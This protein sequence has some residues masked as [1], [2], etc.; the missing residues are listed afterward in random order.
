[1]VLSLLQAR[2]GPKTT[3]RLA[4]VILFMSHLQPFD[5]GF[6]RCYIE[7]QMILE[8]LSIFVRVWHRFGISLITYICLC[9][10]T[11]PIKSNFQERLNFKSKVP[12]NYQR[13]E[14][15]QKLE[16]NVV[17]IGQ[18]LNHQVLNQKSDLSILKDLGT[19][20][21][22]MGGTNRL[23]IKLHYPGWM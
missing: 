23:S 22:Y 19:I 21:Y 3:A 1:M 6:R 5:V 17:L 9:R 7:A 11:Q 8:L 13:D 2:L 4:A 20:L 15:N 18:L 16:N 12:V 14:L 10:E